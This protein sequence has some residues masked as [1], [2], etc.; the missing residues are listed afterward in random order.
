MNRN[1]AMG[2]CVTVLSTD[3]GS[4]TVQN[5]RIG[6]CVTDVGGSVKRC[7]HAADVCVRANI[8]R[9]ARRRALCGHA[10][11]QAGEGVAA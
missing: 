11:T 6:C 4:H 1:T 3:L 5:A 7:P 2:A 10:G 9:R 8:K